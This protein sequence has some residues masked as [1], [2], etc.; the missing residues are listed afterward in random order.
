MDVK[1]ARNYSA[2]AISI[3]GHSACTRAGRC[4]SRDDM[5]G[6]SASSSDF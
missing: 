1:G 4:P 2:S 6:L 3:K 5:G